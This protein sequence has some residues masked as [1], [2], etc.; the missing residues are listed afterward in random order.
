MVDEFEYERRFYCREFPAECDD[1]DAPLLMV[2]SYFL[3]QD[4]FAL[5]LRVQARGVRVPMGSQTDGLTTLMQY[6]EAF[7][8]AYITV[9]GSPVSGTRYEAERTVDA[10]IAA[11]MILRGGTPII[12]NRYSVWIGEDGWNIDVFGANNAGLIVAKVER[13]SPVTNLLIPGFCTTEVTD[14]H[15]FY[16]DGLASRPFIT[17]R[18]DFL[19]GLDRDGAQYSQLFGQNRYE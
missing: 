16:N 8:E 12:K 14:D 5:R 7:R 19:A 13:S 17:W 2:Q 10:D 15:R 4:G 1:G 9:L 18:D 6:R 11:E 3:H